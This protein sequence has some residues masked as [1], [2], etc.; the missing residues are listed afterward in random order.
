MWAGFR[1]DSG[2]EMAASVYGSSLRMEPAVRA[3]GRT[4][5]EGVKEAEG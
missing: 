5:W 3:G 4:S 1:L 2:E